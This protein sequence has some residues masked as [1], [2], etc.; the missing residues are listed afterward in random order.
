[1]FSKRRIASQKASPDMAWNETLSFDLPPDQLPEIS[2][3]VSVKQTVCKTKVQVK[4]DEYTVGRVVFGM[5]TGTPRAQAHFNDMLR[6]PRQ[7]L[8][9][10]H[11]L[12]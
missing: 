11:P 2:L 9:H 5:K 3:I 4:R 6:N 12:Y 1:V 8:A 10:W 7:P